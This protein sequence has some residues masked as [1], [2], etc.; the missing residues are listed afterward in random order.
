MKLNSLEEDN[1]REMCTRAGVK[2]YLVLPYVRDFYSSLSRDQVY[3]REILST[4]RD[5]ISELTNT[6]TTNQATKQAERANIINNNKTFG[7]GT[8]NSDMR[9]IK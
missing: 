4:A 5:K 7:N 3:T 6:E 8:Y 1:I 9:G 2:P